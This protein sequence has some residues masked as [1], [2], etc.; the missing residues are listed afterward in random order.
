[1]RPVLTARGEQDQHCAGHR[2][3]EH[4]SDAPKAG[5]CQ[6]VAIYTQRTMFLAARCP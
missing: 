3:E 4:N 5:A 1:M 2:A 6:E